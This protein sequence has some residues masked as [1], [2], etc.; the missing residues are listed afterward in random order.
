MST[1]ERAAGA[2]HTAVTFSLKVVPAA[3]DKYIELLL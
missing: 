3:T 1:L 2:G